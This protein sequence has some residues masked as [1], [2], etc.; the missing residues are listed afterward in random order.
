MGE[1]ARLVYNECEKMYRKKRFAVVLLILAVLIPIFVYAQSVEI[2][3]TTKRLGTDDWKVALQ[4]QIIDTQNRLNSTGLPEEF[5]KMLKVRV[6]QQQYYLD[7]NINPSEPGAPTFTKLFMEQSLSLFLPLL[8]MIVAIDIVSGE[9]SDGTIKVL[10]TRPIKRW[11]ILLSKYITVILSSSL[12]LFFVGV[13]SY[14][15]SGIA[16]GYK[17]WT[18]PMLTGFE[19]QNGNLIT[20]NVYLI[21]LWK[22]MWMVMGLAWFVVIVVGTICFMVSVLIRNTPAGMGIMLAGLIT[23]GIL[24]GFS[25]SWEGAKYIFSV[26]LS[27]TDYLSG[28][29]PALSGLTFSFSVLVLAAWAVVAILISFIVF[30]R[31]DFLG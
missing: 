26:H 29:L 25:T 9:R 2:K 21:P 8:I 31:Q 3:E 16:F 18:M 24:T 14:L 5:R 10:L 22:Y 15:L 6:D 23:G 13:L 17:G 7:H 20:D 30:I 11:K 19:I 4:Q 28:H 1:F 27:L 12:V